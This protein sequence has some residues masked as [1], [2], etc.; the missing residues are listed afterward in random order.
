MAWYIG[1]LLGCL[2]FVVWPDRSRA[3]RSEEAGEPLGDGDA[4]DLPD[5][6]DAADGQHGAD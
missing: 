5:A 6:A 4:K 2:T 1:V 3:G